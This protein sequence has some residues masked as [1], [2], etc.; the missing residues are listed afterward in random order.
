MQIS[1]LSL[2][3]AVLFHIE[4]LVDTHVYIIE[5][6]MKTMMNTIMN[7]LMSIVFAHKIT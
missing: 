2:Q 1:R 6:M 7:T 5:F 4:G 3:H